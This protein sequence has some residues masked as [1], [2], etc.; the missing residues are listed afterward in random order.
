MGGGASSTQSHEPLGG[1]VAGEQQ[2][3]EG[4]DQRGGADLDAAHQERAVAGAAR[5]HLLGQPARADRDGGDRRDRDGGADA[6]HES[7]GEAAPPAAGA[8]EA[9]RI[10]A[11]VVVA[12]F[13]VMMVVTVT[14]AVMIMVV[15]LMT[16]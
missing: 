3:P 13:I 14:M 7:R 15:M 16:L 1:E 8:G 4:D 12:G 2:R 10:G 6:H 11:V 9:R 5:R